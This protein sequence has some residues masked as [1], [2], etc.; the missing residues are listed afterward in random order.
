MIEISRVTFPAGICC[1]ADARGRRSAGRCL[2]SGLPR[3]CVFRPGNALD[4]PGDAK[5][6]ERQGVELFRRCGIDH[7]VEE[8]FVNGARSDRALN[9]LISGRGEIAAVI[10]F[11]HDQILRRGGCGEMKLEERKSVVGGTSV[12]GGVHLGGRCGSTKI[13][14]QYNY[15]A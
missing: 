9:L 15:T 11:E 12:P 7:H 5:E 13:R 6:L 4:A 14:Y 10:A 3:F 2:R 8:K 1:Q